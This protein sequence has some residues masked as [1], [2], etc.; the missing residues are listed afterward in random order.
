ME[1]AV[2]PADP[3]IS[4]RRAIR[5]ARRPP[6]GRRRASGNQT[7]DADAAARARPNRQRAAVGLDDLAAERQAEAAPG[8]LGREEWQQRV[9]HHVVAHPLA[10]V[11]DADLE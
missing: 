7:D 11:L 3:M 9:L 6:R 10:A 5:A 2:A 8:R 4:L 1:D